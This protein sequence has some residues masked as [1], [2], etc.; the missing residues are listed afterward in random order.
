MADL[1]PVGHSIPLPPARPKQKGREKPG[2][3]QAGA[4]EPVAGKSRK[5][6]VGDGRSAQRVDEYA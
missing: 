2:G 4:K 5:R 6:P 1:E 3:R